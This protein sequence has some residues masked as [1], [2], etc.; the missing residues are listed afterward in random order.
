MAY[1][2]DM[3]QAANRHYIDGKKLLDSNRFQDNGLSC[4]RINGELAMTEVKKR[5]VPGPDL[6]AKTVF[7]KLSKIA[8]PI[9]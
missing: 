1:A 3:E 9:S 6:K 7:V 4:C 2:Q 5:K 8:E